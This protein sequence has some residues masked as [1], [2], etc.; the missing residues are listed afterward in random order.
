MVQESVADNLA[1]KF[2]GAAVVGFWA[3]F[4]AEEGLAAFFQE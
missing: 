2:L 1:D 4:G 3:S